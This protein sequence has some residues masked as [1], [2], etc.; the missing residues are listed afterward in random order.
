MS[1]IEVK[2]YRAQ[3]TLTAA[4]SD[5]ED[6][7]EMLDALAADAEERGFFIEWAVL[8]DMPEGQVIPGSPLDKI[9]KGDDTE[10]A[11]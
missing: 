3:L 1:D 7:G 5:P 6:V 4:H 9:I 10:E 11:P 8:Q 2:P